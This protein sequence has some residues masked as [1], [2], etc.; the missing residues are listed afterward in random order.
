MMQDV[1]VAQKVWGGGIS[2]LK[3]KTTQ[4]KP[5]IVSW[6]Q[7]EIPMDLMKLHKE[8]FLTCDIFWGQDSIISNIKSDNQFHG[9]LSTCKRSQK[10][11]RPSIRCIN[12]TC[13]MVSTSQ[14]Y[15]EMESLSH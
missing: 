6:D 10:F 12:T 3:G 14:W 5:N 4:S 2:M 15:M 1:D 7:V 11:S 13:I 9:R 8:V